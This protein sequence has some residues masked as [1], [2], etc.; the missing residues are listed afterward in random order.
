MSLK[1]FCL[2][3][4]LVHTLYAFTRVKS[5][6]MVAII[7]SYLDFLYAFNE[8]CVYILICLI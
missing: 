5:R 3:S 7:A 8:V 2:L 4:L 1:E 6:C